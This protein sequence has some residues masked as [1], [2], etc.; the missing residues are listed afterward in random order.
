MFPITDISDIELV[1]ALVSN[2][3]PV[4]ISDS[5]MGRANGI[6]DVSIVL[7]FRFLALELSS[8][9]SHCTNPALLVLQ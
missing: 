5:E 8:C 2:K 4:T 1:S 3:F 9:S 7:L 6:F